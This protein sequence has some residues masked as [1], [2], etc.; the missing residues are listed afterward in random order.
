M[1]NN[2]SFTNPYRAMSDLGQLQKFYQE[3]FGVPTRTNNTT[4]EE[5][6]PIIDIYETK[7]EL[8]LESQ[9]PGMNE[10]DFKLSAENNVLTLT[11]ERKFTDQNKYKLHR[12][13]RPQG[14]F[15]R[16]FTV[17]STFDLAK[18]SASYKEG[19]LK[20]NVPKRVEAKPR[21]IEVK[22]V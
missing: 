10:A 3:F 6:S 17:P 11:G 18:V 16:S 14:T 22:I 2:K 20:V 12:Q 5:W 21:Q 19:I 15:E 13:E 8:V 1:K 9:L 4:T 7:D